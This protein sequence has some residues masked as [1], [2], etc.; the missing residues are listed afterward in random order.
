MQNWTCIC[1]QH[2]DC[3]KNDNIKMKN[4]DFVFMFKHSFWVLIRTVSLDLTG[5]HNLCFRTNIR[6]IVYS[7][8]KPSFATYTR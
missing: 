1:D 2:C 7:P 6:K 4:C 5:T 8:A 3:F